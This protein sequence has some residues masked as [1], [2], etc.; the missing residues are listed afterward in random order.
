MNPNYGRF[1]PYS[2][3]LGQGKLRCGIRDGC[4]DCYRLMLESLTPPPEE[5]VYLPKGCF[6]LFTVIAPACSICRRGQSC[7]EKAHP[8][9]RAPIIVSAREA[10][11]VTV[12]V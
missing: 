7:Y 8:E 5:E 1:C 9:F 6:G 3:R 10:E 11:A 4:D 2:V 12:E